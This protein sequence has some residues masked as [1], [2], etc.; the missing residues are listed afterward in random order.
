MHE[1]FAKAQHGV[2]AILFF[3]FLILTLSIV[4]RLA[5][6]HLMKNSDRPIRFKRAIEDL[7]AV[8]VIGVLGMIMLLLVG[9]IK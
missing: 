6:R 1:M 7:A 8:L 2:T 4:S 3:V 9:K 5:V